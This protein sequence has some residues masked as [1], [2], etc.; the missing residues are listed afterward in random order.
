MPYLVTFGNK[1]RYECRDIDDFSKVIYAH[2]RK[3]LI[4]QLGPVFIG[5]EVEIDSENTIVFRKIK[6]SST[7]DFQSISHTRKFYIER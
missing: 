5:D 3:S 4:Y 6:G 2:P 7:Y 1:K